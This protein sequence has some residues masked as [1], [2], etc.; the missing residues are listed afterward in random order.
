MRRGSAAR[1]F[2]HGTT[3]K[4]EEGV[5]MKVVSVIPWYQALPGPARVLLLAFLACL[6][7]ETVEDCRHYLIHDRA[8]LFLVGGG[9]L[10]GTVC[11]I[12]WMESLAGAAVGAGF[13]GVVRA[14][15]RG[16]LGWGDVKLAG[17]LGVWL[18][19]ERTALC[20]GLAFAAGGCVALILLAC[21]RYRRG[22]VLPF[23]PFLCGGAA[24]SL[25][26]GPALLSRYY[27]WI[28]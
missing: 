23:G 3:A 12:P 4:A 20:L 10:F 7:W 16:G 24:L 15:S 13:L 22:S 5:T 2:F 26:Y 6:L 8:V 11:G 19:P 21:R 9:L 27:S 17:G 1:S 25:C 14:A 18:G 28:L